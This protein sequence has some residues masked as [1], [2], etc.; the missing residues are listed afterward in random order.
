MIRGYEIS[1]DRFGRSGCLWTNIEASF[2]AGA[3]RLAALDEGGWR[4]MIGEGQ[5]ADY[6]RVENAG[7][8]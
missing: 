2:A 8:A 1:L 6:L 3:S 7:G 4:R 5:P